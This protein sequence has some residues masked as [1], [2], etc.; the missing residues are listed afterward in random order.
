[1]LLSHSLARDVSY[2]VFWFGKH[3]FCRVC[4]LVWSVYQDAFPNVTRVIIYLRLLIHWR[5]TKKGCLQMFLTQFCDLA[6]TSFVG[7]APSCV[8]CLLRVLWVSDCTMKVCTRDSPIH[9]PPHLKQYKQQMRCSLWGK[10]FPFKPLKGRHFACFD[11]SSAA[12]EFGK[13]IVKHF[14]TFWTD[15]LYGMTFPCQPLYW[16]LNT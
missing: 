12:I 11:L 15:I 6:N 7:C 3:Q 4:P 2:T 10:A 13:H 9:G 5:S 16:F 1:M 8:K 14:V